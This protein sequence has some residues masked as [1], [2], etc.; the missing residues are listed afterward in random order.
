MNG[1][2]YC[3]LAFELWLE[4]LKTLLVIETGEE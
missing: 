3:Q 2:L 4:N 1:L